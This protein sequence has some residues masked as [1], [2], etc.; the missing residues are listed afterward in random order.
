VVH[1]NARWALL[2]DRLTANE[3][4]PASMPQPPAELRQKIVD[5]VKARRA[6]EARRTAG[7]PGIVLARRL[8]NAE[9]DYTIRDLTGVDM[10][11]A[12]EF[13]VDPANTAGFDNSGESLSMS[14]ALLN[15][16][17]QAAHEVADRMAL[18]PDG[19]DFA[20]YPMLVETD[21]DKY[22]I[23]RIVD[24][25]RRQPTD[26]AAYFEAAWRYEYRSILGKPAATLASTAADAKV[27]A[28]YLA[29]IWPLLEESGDAAKREV[30]PIAKLQAMWRALPAPNAI[31]PDANG[32][33][34]RQQCRAMRDFVVK[35][36]NHT[37]MQYAAPVVRG[38]PGASQ[39]LLNWKLWEFADHR[40]DSDHRDLLNDNEPPPAVPPVPRYPGL[41]QEAA[42]RWAALTANARAGDADLVV[43]AAERGSYEAAFARFASIFPDTFYVSER[44][45]YFPDD[46]DDKGRLL[47]AG[48]HNTM[49]YFRDDRPLME[50]ILDEKGQRELN[51]LWDEF[52]FIAEYTSR[53]FVQYYFNE[54]GEVLGNGAE[55][56]SL[57]PTDHRVTD[58]EVIFGLRD[59]YLA[60]A[61]ASSNNDPLAAEAIRVHFQRVNDTLRALERMHADAEPRHLQALLKF[62]ARAYRRP[63]SRAESDD[64]LAYYHSLREK[65]GLTHEEAIRDSIVSVLMSPDFCYRIDLLESRGSGGP[66]VIRASTGV[67]VTPLSGYALASRLSY[68]LWASMPDEELLAHAAA[69]DL[70]RPEVLLAETRRM[71]KDERIRGLATEFGGNWLDFLRFESHNGVDRE[72]FPSFN[73]DLREAMFQEPIRFLEDVIR[74]GRAALNLIYGNYTFVNP[75]LARHYGMPA[76]DGGED[77]WVRVDNVGEYGRG[78]LLGMAVFL[79]QNSPGLRTSPVKR[80]H[81]VVGRVIGETIPPPPPVV[82][83]L[84][85][86]ES[87]SDLPVRDMLA[88]HRANPVC[89]SCHAKFDSFGLALEG[90][91]PVGEARTKDLAGRQVETKAAFPGGSEGSGIEGIKAYIRERRESQYLDNL[92]RKLLAYAL[93]R[94]LEL[95][96][97]PVIER[98]QAKLASSGYRFDTLVESIVTSPQFM[99]K[100]RPDP[101]EK[102]IATKER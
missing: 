36:R 48:Y 102:A 40:R 35:I 30:G 34:L 32:A 27:S 26:Y 90:Y 63:L 11:L 50:L 92:S 58:A 22:C 47:S 66:G 95:S 39:P 70:Q 14:P 10:R 96:D 85:V 49:G 18:T 3:M 45:R 91:G 8:S 67:P 17:L 72:R 71:L 21:R 24:F 52:D 2:A 51:R 65:S 98:M 89:A 37:A 62:A 4:P 77:H 76:V 61:A 69:G 43:P 6:D 97:E 56:G 86:D 5:W 75:S 59:A 42:P 93:N 100:R 23:Q 81:W 82:P 55:S 68:F 87:K 60:K 53:T 44:G 15:K 7:D 79:T 88:A 99:N 33:A 101:R 64:I 38:L 20:P 9:Y 13:P 74:N 28:K 16:Y 94:S 54:S 29:I 80:G 83:E 25:Y 84:P 73:N 46:S 19:I 12:R 78:G 57:R 1:D 41:H 31:Q